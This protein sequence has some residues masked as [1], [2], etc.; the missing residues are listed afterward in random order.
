[1]LCIIYRHVVSDIS[2]HRDTLKSLQR[3]TLKGRNW[4]G[5]VRLYL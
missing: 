4:T 2:F 5:M 1:M 3:D